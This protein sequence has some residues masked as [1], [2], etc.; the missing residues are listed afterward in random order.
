MQV[1]DKL[2][3]GIKTICIH[4]LHVSMRVNFRHT[5]TKKLEHWERG[6]IGLTSLLLLLLLLENKSNKRSTL[7]ISQLARLTITLLL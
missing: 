4:D 7:H 6:K 3:T 5:D 2:F 1:V